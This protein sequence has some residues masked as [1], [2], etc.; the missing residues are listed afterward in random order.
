MSEHCRR[1]VRSASWHAPRSEDRNPTNG[2]SAYAT[3]PP[4]GGGLPEARAEQRA[5]G[6]V[7]NGFYVLG[8]RAQACRLKKTVL[9]KEKE[10][11]GVWRA[12]T[13]HWAKKGG[14]QRPR[15]VA[16]CTPALCA[17]R[18]TT[19]VILRRVSRAS[20]TE[21]ADGGGRAL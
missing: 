5:G 16:G 4:A 7:E 6:G 3:A 8:L 18:R 19:P 9:G 21:R 14:H 13:T 2:S 1:R 12:P 11:R 17:V 15:R 20:P 10:S